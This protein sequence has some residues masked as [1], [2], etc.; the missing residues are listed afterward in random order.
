M[1]PTGDAVPPRGPTFMGVRMNGKV[2]EIFCII[3]KSGSMYNVGT[4]VNANIK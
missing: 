2:T 4:F 3:D 1:G